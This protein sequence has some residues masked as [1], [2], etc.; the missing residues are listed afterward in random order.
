MPFD[1]PHVFLSKLSKLIKKNHT[2]HRAVLAA[3]ASSHPAHSWAV[4]EN[5]ARRAGGLS[6]RLPQPLA[7]TAKAFTASC[8]LI[9]QDSMAIK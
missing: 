4:G 7:F 8:L 1:F 3:F 9:G 5:L 6:T 2:N